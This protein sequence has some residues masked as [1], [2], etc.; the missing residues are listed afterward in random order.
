MLGSAEHKKR[1]KII[2]RILNGGVNEAV[3][4]AKGIIDDHVSLKTDE[5]VKRRAGAIKPANTKARLIT[6]KGEVQ[7][8]CGKIRNI[9]GGFKAQLIPLKK[10]YQQCK[11]YL[12]AFRVAYGV[13]EAPKQVNLQ[14]VL[15]TL[16]IFVT[17]EAGVNTVF[18]Q[19]NGL[20]PNIHEAAVFA[21]M[22]SGISIFASFMGGYFCGRYW[23]FHAHPEKKWLARIGSLIPISITALALFLT[24]LLRATEE[25]SGFRNISSEAYLI[26]ENTHSILI[27]LIGGLFSVFAWYEGYRSF[28]TIPGLQEAAK[29][30][31][32][33]EGE[34]EEAYEDAQDDIDELATEAREK[35]AAFLEGFQSIASNRNKQLATPK[36]ENAEMADF[37]QK[38]ATRLNSTKAL[39]KD[40]GAAIKPGQK[41]L[42]G[43][44]EAQLKPAVD[45][46]EF[47]IESSLP[48]ISPQEI[49]QDIKELTAL[50]EATVEAAQL[51]M[52]TAYE[53]FFNDQHNKEA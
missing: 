27:L 18:L 15:A 20:L 37:Q 19:M 48:K 47:S 39:Y 26:L 52:I 23:N 30:V 2:D 14:T 6:L 22:A 24:A 10:K 49:E 51:D 50:L 32:D 40:I 44:G 17:L 25:F 8:T 41:I 45:I 21:A 34:T 11:Q 46:A 4:E 31:D 3:Y 33:L 42:N 43:A 16:A 5:L 53:D 35:I 7:Q 9:S 29:P 28:G 38:G 1:R 36:K 13:T 12:A